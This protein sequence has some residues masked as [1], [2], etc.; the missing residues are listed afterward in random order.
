MKAHRLALS[1]VG[2]LMLSACSSL[3]P[4]SSEG[5]LPALK[6]LASPVGMSASWRARVDEAG[7]FWGEH[8][9]FLG[10]FG[11]IGF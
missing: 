2:M 11:Q 7:V 8:R 9:G 4:F 5:K 3:N 1:L 10:F 6:P